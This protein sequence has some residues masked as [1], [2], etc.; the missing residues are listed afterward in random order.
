M[1]TGLQNLG[2]R[3]LVTIATLGR[4]HLFLLRLLAAQAFL[5][6]RPG[7][8]IPQLYSV[9]VRS[10]PII[11]VSGLFVGMVLG[12]QGYNTLVYYGA[13]ASLGRAVAKS[14][15]QELGPVVAALLYAGR[16]GSALTA[17]I[18]LMKT[19]E[20]LDSM[21]MMAVDPFPRVLAPRFLA[22]FIALPLLAAIF[23]AVGIMGGYFIAVEQLG[24]DSGAYWSQ[25]QV[26]VDF[27]REV[28]DGVLVKSLVF[29]LVANWIALFEGYDTAPTSE[30]IS[31]ATTNTVVTTSLAVLG[32][33]FILTALLFG[34]D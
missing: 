21:T 8:L 6:T 28:I 5:F 23:S 11:I 31:R 3:T 30:G 2:H 33:D 14:L 26:S 32:L 25:M 22:G 12:L 13:E 24:V 1:I 19:T 34:E 9:G 16:A 29:A 27:Y 17:E 20:Q 15:L 4:S 7:L 10:L 18:G